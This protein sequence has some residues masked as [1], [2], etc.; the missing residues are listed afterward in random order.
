MLNE[1]FSLIFKHRE[2]LFRT[3]KIINFVFQNWILIGRYEPSKAQS[4]ATSKPCCAKTLW[5][6]YPS[7]RP[8]SAA[9]KRS[10]TPH[11][12]KKNKRTWPP[13]P[14]PPTIPRMKTKTE[15][16][17]RR[18]LVPDPYQRKATQQ[19]RP[20]SSRKGFGI[21]KK[22]RLHLPRLEYVT[23]VGRFI[24]SIEDIR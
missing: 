17:L 15:C 5:S 6:A 23:L 14:L 12:P 4:S 18:Q 10:P 1:I 20:K 21:R 13:L 3:L 22:L 11:P 16:G 2:A 9:A 8:T 19:K 24:R 7:R